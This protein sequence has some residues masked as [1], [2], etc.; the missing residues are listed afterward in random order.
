MRDLAY[1][2]VNLVDNVLEVYRLPEA[3]PD[4]PYGG[5]YQSTVTL[6]TGDRVSPLSAPSAVILVADLLP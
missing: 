5:R 1:W 3:D 6:R 2:I 4:S